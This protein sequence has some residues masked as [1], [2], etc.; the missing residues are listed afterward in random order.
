MVC[1]RGIPILGHI[2]YGVGLVRWESGYLGYELGTHGH[3]TFGAL[4]HR[5]AAA[6]SFFLFCS[7]FSLFS[8]SIPPSNEDLLESG[9]PAARLAYPRGHPWSIVAF[10]QD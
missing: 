10:S 4:G 2:R 5:H 9:I 3:M 1:T 7:L 8:I 6:F